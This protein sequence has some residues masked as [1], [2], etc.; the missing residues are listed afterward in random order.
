MNVWIVRF[1][2][3]GAPCAILAG[4]RYPPAELE[5]KMTTLRTISELRRALEP[6]KRASTVG[7]V[8]TMGALHQGHHALFRAAREECDVV[9]ASVFVNPAQFSDAGDLERYPRDLDRDEHEAAAAGVDL[10][11]APTA[12]EFYPDG[13]ATWVDPAGAALGLE[14]EHRGGH[15]RGVATAC[16]KLFSIVR[17]Q[18]AYFGRKDAQQVAVVKQV[19]RDLNLDLEIRVV[20]TVRDADGLA[21]SSRNVLLT[22]EERARACAIPA[23]LATGDPERARAMLAAAGLE[24]EY[25]TIADLD[26]PTLAVAARVGTTRLIDNVLLEGEPR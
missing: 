6:R 14:G 21:L 26:G 13:F 11:F 7:L 19:V 1:A 10:L 12:D 25:L 17:P 8:P 18:I 9:I 5:Q 22:S 4:A 16:V 23:A 3:D 24:P 2:S 20:P 15:F